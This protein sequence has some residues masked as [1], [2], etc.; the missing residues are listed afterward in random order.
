MAK[1][2]RYNRENAGRFTVAKSSHYSDTITWSEFTEIYKLQVEPSNTISINLGICCK[3]PSFPVHL[4][5]LMLRREKGCRVKTLCLDKLW[6]QAKHTENRQRR[7]NAQNA[8]AA[9]RK[10]HFELYSLTLTGSARFTECQS[11]PTPSS[12]HGTDVC[13]AL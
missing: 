13:S 7:L 8:S 1:V 9:E 4:W 5:R 6:A 3:M 2:K 10:K 12:G 11:N